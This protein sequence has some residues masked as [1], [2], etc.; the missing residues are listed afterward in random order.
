MTWLALNYVINA[1]HFFFRG[2]HVTN[3]ITKI[4]WIFF[5]RQCVPLCLLAV[6]VVWFVS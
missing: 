5:P 4:N 2:Y 3:I 6:L 1:V